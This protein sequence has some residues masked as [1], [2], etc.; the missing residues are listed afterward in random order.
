MEQI[1]TWAPVIII[2]II[3]SAFVIVI[4]GARNDQY[5]TYVHK[6]IEAEGIPVNMMTYTKGYGDSWSC[7]KI[8][9]KVEVK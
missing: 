7:V 1:E 9:R 6:C 2:S 5:N 4:F 3:V 8:D